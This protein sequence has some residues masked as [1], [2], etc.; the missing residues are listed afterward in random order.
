MALVHL[1]QVPDAPHEQAREFM[2]A[3]ASGEIGVWEMLFLQLVI[4]P[5]LRRTRSEVGVTLVELHKLAARLTALDVDGNPVEKPG[6]VKYLLNNDII[7]GTTQEAIDQG[8]ARVVMEMNVARV[9][10]L[11]QEKMDD[12]M[13]WA[14]NWSAYV[15]SEDSPDRMRLHAAFEGFLTI[16]P[17]YPQVPAAHGQ[18]DQPED[19]EGPAT[20]PAS[21]PDCNPCSEIPDWAYDPQF[22]PYWQGDLPP[23]AETT[24]QDDDDD[25]DFPAWVLDHHAFNTAK[26]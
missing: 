18:E 24:T 3:I 13:S 1:F 25:D 2:R 12:V 20:A 5:R 16:R 21:A 23:R 26:N 14:C 22:R 19:P 15:S 11:E 6:L 8:T 9:T 17:E 7:I 4:Y 10:P